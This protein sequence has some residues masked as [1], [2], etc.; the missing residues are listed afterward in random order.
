MERSEIVG[1]FEE[2]LDQ[3]KQRI[4]AAA[5]ND[6]E[7]FDEMG[8]TAIFAGLMQ[9]AETES[10]HLEDGEGFM[11][12]MALSSLIIAKMARERYPEVAKK[13]DKQDHKNLAKL[14]I[15]RK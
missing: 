14:E 6:G 9:S 10:P 12:D 5:I 3:T 7:I 1:L 4:R 11:H 13:F 2:I 8:L 15:F